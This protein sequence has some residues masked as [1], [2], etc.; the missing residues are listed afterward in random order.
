MFILI[1]AG[2]ALL[3]IRDYRDHLILNRDLLLLAPIFLIDHHCAS[4]TLVLFAMFLLLFLPLITVGGGDIKLLALLFLTQ[5]SIIFTRI[6]LGY[7][8]VALTLAI[9]I[10][11]ISNGRKNGSIALA[12]PILCAFLAAYLSQ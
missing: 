10:F 4:L 3:S 9:L 12:P 5:G 7:L 8:L 2:S 11:Y 6:F 1:A